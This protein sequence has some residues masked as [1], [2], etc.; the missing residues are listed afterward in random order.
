MALNSASG[1]VRNIGVGNFRNNA[2][3]V[4]E[5]AQTGAQYNGGSGRKISLATD[6]CY[7]LLNMFVKHQ[8]HYGESG[9]K[10]T[11]YFPAALSAP[12]N[13]VAVTLY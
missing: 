4:G 8:V 7:S 3:I 10:N 2:E 6:K 5:V 1:K 12:K 9:P 13:R 11:K